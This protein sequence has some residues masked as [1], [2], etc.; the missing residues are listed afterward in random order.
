MTDDLKTLADVAMA[1]PDSALTNLKEAKTTVADRIDQAE[2]LIAE[3]AK[4]IAAQNLNI[5]EQTK[6]INKINEANLS[7]VDQIKRLDGRLVILENESRANLFTP[8]IN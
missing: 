8:P 3:L 1:D 5:L 2:A 7:L 6:T 4:C